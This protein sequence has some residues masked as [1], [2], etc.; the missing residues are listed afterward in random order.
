MT[1][2]NLSL[3]TPVWL[4]KEDTQLARPNLFENNRLLKRGKGIGRGKDNIK[5]DREVEDGRG[6]Y[7][8]SMW[9]TAV[10]G[11]S[12]FWSNSYR[13]FAIVSTGYFIQY[14]LCSTCMYWWD[15][16]KTYP[17]WKLILEDFEDVKLFLANTISK[18]F[19]F[20]SF[21]FFPNTEKKCCWFFDQDKWCESKIFF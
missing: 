3:K 2:L 12:A 1:G 14:C 9:D 13:F 4:K 18:A 5:W 6:R 15:C 19:T 10:S 17:Q 21:I 7:S 16:S 11:K 8:E 20:C